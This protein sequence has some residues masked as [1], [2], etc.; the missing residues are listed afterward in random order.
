MR[1]A[2]G[3]ELRTVCGEKIIVAQGL[4]HIN[5]NK[6]VVLN[7]TA[8]CLWET[9]VERDFTEQDWID[10]LISQYDVSLD[11]ITSDVQTLIT[12]FRAE[13]MIEGV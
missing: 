8:S 3:F 6:V 12:K 1:I 2:K 10:C 13:G 7:E 9:F 11:V 4:E 5:F